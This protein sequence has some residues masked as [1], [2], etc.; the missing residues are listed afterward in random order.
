MAMCVTVVAVRVTVGA[1]SRMFRVWSG[2]RGRVPMGIVFMGWVLMR[3][4]GRDGVRLGHG[5]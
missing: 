2:I 3:F 5:I 4:V 1:V